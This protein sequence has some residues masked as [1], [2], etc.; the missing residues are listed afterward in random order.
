M[1][2][3]AIG[4]DPGARYTGVSVINRD[5]SEVILSSTYVRPKEM[6]I[7]TWGESVAR[8]ISEDVLS[9]YPEAIV[10]IEG[11]TTP[12]P[13]HGGKLNLMNPKN[14]IELAIAAGAIAMAAVLLSKTVVIVRP[15]KNGSQ[16]TYPKVLVGVRPKDLPGVNQKAGTR[17]HERSA[18]DVAM[19][20]E[21]KVKNGFILDQ[22]KGL[23]D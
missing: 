15:G 3:I 7:F 23:F 18:Y 1:I 10:G 21:E 14:T 20:T 5:T 6:P 2:K 11:V 19:L 12:N 16:E 22:Q 9:K 8:Q 17:N 4:I 13:Y